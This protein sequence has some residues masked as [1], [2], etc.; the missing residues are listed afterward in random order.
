MLAPTKQQLS[1]NLGVNFPDEFV[2]WVSDVWDEIPRPTG[3]NRGYI[4]E[5]WNEWSEE[6]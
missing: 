3:W 4:Q 5:L 1:D 2:Q 6:K